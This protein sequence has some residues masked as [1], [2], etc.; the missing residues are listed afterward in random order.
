MRRMK[1]YD[2]PPGEIIKGQ[3]YHRR[4]DGYGI[5]TVAYIQRNGQEIGT[6][7]GCKMRGPHWLGR[8]ELMTEWELVEQVKLADN[9]QTG[10]THTFVK[11]DGKMAALGVYHSPSTRNTSTTPDRERTE[12]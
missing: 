10:R 8:N 3:G 12:S 2:P 6:L 1:Y 7:L 9:P 4:S 5:E 11:R